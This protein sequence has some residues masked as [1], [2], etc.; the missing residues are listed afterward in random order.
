[1][2]T[3]FSRFENAVDGFF[4]CGYTDNNGIK[5]GHVTGNAGRILNDEFIR[6]VIL[7]L[8]LF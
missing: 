7:G 6:F 2:L 1:V 3:V 4:L 8:F 5:L